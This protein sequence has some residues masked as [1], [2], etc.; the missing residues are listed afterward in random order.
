MLNGV[1]PAVRT[2]PA[3]GSRAVAA[4]R[5]RLQGMEQ[6]MEVTNKIFAQFVGNA[7]GG[8]TRVAR[9]LLKALP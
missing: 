1:E 2:A 3:T 5:E 4:T 6:F 7:K 8:L 9:V